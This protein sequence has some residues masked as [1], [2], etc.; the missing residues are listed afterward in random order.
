MRGISTIIGGEMLRDVA[1]FVQSLDSMFGG[2]Q[3]RAL[4]TYELL[5][6]P[7]TR[8]VV[9]AAAGPTPCARPRSSWTGCRRS[10]CRWPG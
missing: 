6:R 9:V 1:M 2:F 7:G 5:K 10:R 4:Q 3:E 8:F